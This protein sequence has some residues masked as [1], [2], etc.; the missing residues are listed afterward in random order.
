MTNNLAVNSRD[1]KVRQL[2][3]SN[4]TRG[5]SDG[6]RNL[7]INHLI[8]AVLRAILFNYS[9]KVNTLEKVLGFNLYGPRYWT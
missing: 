1:K 5:I 6:K 3:H 2:A 9:I 7:Y 4:Y 8:V